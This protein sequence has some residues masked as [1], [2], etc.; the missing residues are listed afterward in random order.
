MQRLLRTAS[1]DA[2]RVRDE[3]L[4][5]IVVERLAHPDGVLICDETG[6][7][8]KGVCSAGVQRQYTGTAGRVENAQV[9]VFCP[10]PPRTGGR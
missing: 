8:T 9:G 5:S 1:W 2:G 7:L 10:T 3:V 6:F 4:R